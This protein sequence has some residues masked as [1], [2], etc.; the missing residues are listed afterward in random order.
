MV[1]RRDITLTQLTYFVEAAE[2]GSM[3]AAADE[4]RV[5][6]SAISTSI[7]NL[8]HSLGTRLFVRRRAKGLMLT[9][10]GAELLGRARSILA[11]V[12]DALDALSPDGFAGSL[13]VG[14][15][16]TL[17]PFYLPSILEGFDT[18]YP[19]LSLDVTELTL[20]R[21]R[22][23]LMDHSVEAALT[24]DLGLGP[25]IRSEVLA[26]V[27]VYAAVGQ[28]HALAHR[29]SV[30]LHE[31]IHEPMVLLDLPVS[32]DYF[33]RVFTD[34]GLRPTVRYR[35]FDY[36]GVRA[37]VAAGRGFTL[38]NQQPK[39][40]YTY[41]GTQLRHL[42]IQEPT[43]A[44]NLV[45]ARLDADVVTHKYEVFLEHCRRAVVGGERESH[46]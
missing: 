10:A 32:R 21:V 33:L 19:D 6:Q 2:T 23:S 39:V 43:P 8:E 7:G 30:S 18:Q 27:P 31:L 3:T 11:S 9:A 44:L 14:C 17:V 34:H 42:R 22:E 45:V 25:E 15:F 29:E 12:D 40:D 41:S 1:S 38:L 26:T 16:R 28:E 13:R 46:T 37:M 36:E 35:F 5:A 20:D 4:L 24:Y